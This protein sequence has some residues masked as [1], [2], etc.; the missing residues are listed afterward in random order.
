MPTPIPAATDVLD[1][2]IWI[3][4]VVM[5]Q[6]TYPNEISFTGWRGNRSKSPSHPDAPL[7]PPRAPGVSGP[8][9]K[10]FAWQL[11]SG[12]DVRG[13]PWDC[14]FPRVTLSQPQLV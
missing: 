4:L 7:S 5:N 6:V 3:L 12:F 9:Q 10:Y 1:G 11:C 13:N 14:P 8:D 2:M